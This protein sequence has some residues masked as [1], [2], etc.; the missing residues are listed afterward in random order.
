[1]HVSTFAE[2]RHSC[3]KTSYPAPKA[4]TRYPRIFNPPVYFGGLQ[5]IRRAL[6]SATTFTDC[7]G[8]ELIALPVAMGVALELLLCEGELDS[9]DDA[10]EL[11]IILVGEGVADG[12]AGVPAIILILGNDGKPDPSEVYV[13]T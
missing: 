7:G 2:V 4:S 10:A 9:C 3:I 11:G 1:M 8:D 13:R 5:E 6:E 12:A